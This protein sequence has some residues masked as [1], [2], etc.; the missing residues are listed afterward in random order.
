MD[1][2]VG[3]VQRLLPVTAHVAARVAAA[4]PSARILGTERMGSAV[5]V[6]SRGLLLTVNYVVMGAR[7]LRV[8][9]TDGR[10]L[11][12]RVVAQD[13][14]SGLA[15]LRVTATG[16]RRTCRR[17]RRCSCSPQRVRPTAASREGW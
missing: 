13:F 14:D 6:E 12:A 3:L 4:H 11:D 1:A 17:D 9:L 8:T 5:V 10:R 7:R 2:A 15:L 16:L